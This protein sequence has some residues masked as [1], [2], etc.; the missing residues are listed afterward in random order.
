MTEAGVSE[1]FIESLV[2]FPSVSQDSNLPLIDFV[3]STLAQLGIASVRV[4]DASGSKSSLFATIGPN[5]PG[6]VVLS[7]HSDVVPATDQ[8][9]TSD[10]FTLVRR[11]DRLYG[12][13]TTDMK[14]FVAIGLAL[15]P[16]MLAAGLKRPI[17]LA[18]SYDEEIG[19]LGA[20]DMIA[21]MLET[22]APPS[23]VIVGEPTGMG[24]VTGH[25]GVLKLTTRVRGKAV[26]SSVV[27]QGV[28][29][30]AIA[31]RLAVWLDDRMGRN[32]ERGLQDMRFSPPYTT[33]HS[34][35]IE[36]G[37]A[38]N[39]TAGHARLVSD[40]RVLPGESAA[41][42]LA[43]Y[44]A[45]TEWLTEA[46][47]RIDPG[48]G[49]DISVECDVPGC[50]R[51]PDGEAEKLAR[52][53]SSAGLPQPDDAVVAYGTEAGQFQAAGLSTV[54]CGP[55]DM[56]Q[57]HKPDEYIELSQ[58]RAGEAFQRRLIAELAA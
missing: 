18:L 44:T 49:I 22:V 30:V 34:G 14:S 12:R 50:R 3:Q 58:V 54:V 36:G 27:D 7:G 55:G 39:I 9:W 8:A 38:F 16:E 26:H 10:P 46:M 23:A 1:A 32:R 33:L 47:R 6:G 40:I 35:I 48:A 15:V 42:Y 20:P 4:P 45:H 5:V 24:V 21:Q 41:D 19:C 57:G 52:R 2:G 28:S 51:E 56:E 37:T 11:G 53:L 25:K 31:A 29:A 17:H 43:E 13:G